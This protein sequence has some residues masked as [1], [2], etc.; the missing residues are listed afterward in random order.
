MNFYDPIFW[1]D[2]NKARRGETQKRRIEDF[3]RLLSVCHS[4][5]PEKDEKT[6]EVGEGHTQPPPSTYHGHRGGHSV[7]LTHARIMSYLLPLWRHQI[8]FSASSPDDEAL[9]CAAKY[10]G[11]RFEGRRDGAAQIRTNHGM[12]NF[13]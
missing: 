10:F 9:V 13:K 3:F 11:F 6:G 5:T 1:D 4:V 12:E 7:P 8:K 2:L